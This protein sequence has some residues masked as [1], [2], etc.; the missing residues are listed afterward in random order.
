MA[1]PELPVRPDV[2]TA[3]GSCPRSGT[4]ADAAVVLSGP[5]DARLV[6]EACR[7]HQKAVPVAQRPEYLL[8]RAARFA[9]CS[10]RCR[11]PAVTEVRGQL[12]RVVRVVG[13]DLHGFV[14]ERNA[15]D[16]RIRRT[17]M[18]YQ[19]HALSGEP[20]PLVTAETQFDQMRGRRHIQ[21][22]AQARK[23]CWGPEA[24]LVP[25]KLPLSVVGDHRNLHFTG[26]ERAPLNLKRVMSN[27][28]AFALH[29]KAIPA[30]LRASVHGDRRAMCRYRRG[31]E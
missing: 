12:A 26:V 5:R 14:V 16:A 15:A 11:S 17:G 18:R 13:D 19:A 20:G 4:P 10:I 25:L 30:P 23:I 3:T 28:A 1:S 24:P 8:D 31:G 7:I 22:Q 29:G 27:G 9:G 6:R 21:W 2:N